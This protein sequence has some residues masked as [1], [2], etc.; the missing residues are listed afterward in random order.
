M[1]KLLFSALALVMVLTLAACGSNNRDM[2]NGTMQVEPSATPNVGTMQAE[3]SAMPNVATNENSNSVPTPSG[4]GVELVKFPENYAEGV[5][6]A[7]VNRGNTKEESYTSREAIEAVKN[8]QPIPSGTVITLLI[9]K[10]GELSKYFVMEK[11]T[12]W[13][14]QYSPKKRNG[15]WEYQAFNPDKSAS[16]TDD[17]DRC[18]SCHMS[19]ENQDFV[20]TLDRMKSVK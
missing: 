20:N 10:D 3:P 19:Q 15:E 4:S 2:T 17:I 12:G 6:Y 13:G 1:K 9:Y 8:G 5:L 14:A 16:I 7:T 18:F 11:R